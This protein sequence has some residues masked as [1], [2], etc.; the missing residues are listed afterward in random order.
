MSVGA[1]WNEE[2]TD[3]IKACAVAATVYQIG[4]FPKDWPRFVPLV[5]AILRVAAN[6]KLVARELERLK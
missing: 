5:E 4:A 2:V 1:E 3:T 6:Q